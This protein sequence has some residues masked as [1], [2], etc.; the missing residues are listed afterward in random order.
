MKSYTG[1]EF[2]P[3]LKLLNRTYPRPEGLTLDW[4]AAGFDLRFHGTKITVAFLPIAFG[5]PIWA[6][7]YLDGHR[8]KFCLDG[9]QPRIYL[10]LLPEG[11][12]FLRVIRM[13]V[14]KYPLTV[15]EIG[16]DGEL[17]SPPEEKKRKIAFFGDSITCGFGDDAEEGTATYFSWCEDCTAAYAYRTAEALDADYQIVSVSGQGMR[18]NCHGEVTEE[19]IPLLFEKTSR[20]PD[21]PP[22]DH[23]GFLPDFVV[24]NAG[25][26]D[27]SHTEPSAFGALVR[28]FVVRIRETYPDAQ[29]VWFYGAMSFGYLDILERTFSDLRKNDS[30]VWFLPVESIRH[31]AGESGTCGHPNLI[32]QA[33]IAKTLTAFLSELYGKE[34]P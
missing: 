17:L 3:H 24:V 2:L 22:Y 20:I 34:N 13:G 15:S 23:R 18:T 21:A 5:M 25:T 12:H 7:V 16:C 4:A 6:V 26:N 10:D 33:R 28:A 11:E 1:I 14:Q 31:R 30:R 29:I 27:E 19:E 32:G 8:Q 9:S